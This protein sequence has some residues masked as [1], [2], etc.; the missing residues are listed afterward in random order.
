MTDLLEARGR[1]FEF[2]LF[3]KQASRIGYHHF[4]RDAADI[5]SPIVGFDDHPN[6]D[7]VPRTINPA[8]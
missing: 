8:I 7:L 2:I 5:L 1:K 3:D 6:P 4:K